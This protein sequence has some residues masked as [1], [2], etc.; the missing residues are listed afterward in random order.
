MTLNRRSALTLLGL[1]ATPAVAQPLRLHEGA[2]SFEHG[3]ASGD[4]STTGGIF[5]TRVTP[6]PGGEGDVMLDLEVA[7]D[8][9]FRQVVRRS[10]GLRA[11]QSR[12]WTIKHDLDGQGLKPG[13]EYWYRFRAIK[14]G[15]LSP[16]GRFKTLPTETAEVVLAVASCALHP[17]GLF[18]AYDAIAKLE[19]LDAVVHLGDYI[20]EYGA[21]P[22]D[23]GM[24][25]GAQLSRVPQPPKEIVTLADYRLR[26]AQYKADPDLQAA[27]AR[28]PWI[29]VWD[30]HE[31]TN[32]SWL[33]GAENH[34][35]DS[36]EGDWAARKAAALQAYYEWMP[37]REPGRGRSR[38]MLERS[39][40]F[41][42]VASLHM[43][44]TRLTARGEQ[45]S[46]DKDL[47]AGADGRPDTAAFQARR[48]AAD[49]R[50][51]GAAQLASLEREVR[52]S[53][54]AGTTWQVLGNQVVMARVQGPN[55]VQLLGQAGVEKVLATLDPAVRPRLQRM[56]QLFTQPLPWNLDAWDGYPAER[57]RLY[58]AL[59]GAGARPIVLAGDSHAFWVNELKDASGA[60]VGAE[61]G[62]S[63]ITS[64]SY[65]DS[66]KGFDFGAIVAAQNEEVVFSDQAAK[67]FTL[68]TLT[69]TEV[70]GDLIAVS[71]ILAK[72]YE[73]R[74]IKRFR[75]TREVDGLSAPTAV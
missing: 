58:G 1:G 5:W 68:L 4:P 21:A 66:L 18:N 47:P 17:G 28:A 11:R 40:R 20:Y 34:D 54:K 8:S 26:H 6:A 67:G 35:P 39:F 48:N 3:V 57:E 30:D 49:R 14:S 38:E 65:G 31:T 46:Y 42:K 41:G 24:T 75:V 23:Y 74:T 36:G 56:A 61:F 64:P 10:S 25:V 71:T 60:R 29:V 51:L 50:L 63:S 37:I 69:P 7:A 44:E 19:R 52:A 62:T 70:R 45:L 15:T 12:D 22:T 72:P 73:S 43:V 53:V 27:H 33:G 16:V 32:D 2:V 13:T 59:K 9:E 55:F